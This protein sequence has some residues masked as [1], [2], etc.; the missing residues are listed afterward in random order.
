MENNAKV[1]HFRPDF[2]LN[3][4]SCLTLLCFRFQD[5]YTKLFYLEFILILDNKLNHDLCLKR[6]AGEFDLIW[7]HESVT[8]ILFQFLLQFLLAIFYDFCFQ[9]RYPVFQAILATFSKRAS[10]TSKSNFR[11]FGL[12]T[13]F[14]VN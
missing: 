9:L 1:Q 10:I 12:R 6:V 13:I 8:P 3:I 14:F 4:L 11:N 7:M 2:I 5:N